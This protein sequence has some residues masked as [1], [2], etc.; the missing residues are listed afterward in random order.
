MES[1]FS[2]LDSL[3]AAVDVFDRDDL[4]IDAT[5]VLS[6]SRNKHNPDPEAVYGYKSDKERFTVTVW[7]Q[8]QERSVKFPVP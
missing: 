2:H 4:V 5:E 8:W 6:N 3:L 1:I 7:Y